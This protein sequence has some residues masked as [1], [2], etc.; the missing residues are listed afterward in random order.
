MK[1]MTVLTRRLLA[2][3]AG[4]VIALAIGGC[5]LFP[6]RDPDAGTPVPEASEP[7]GESQLPLMSEPPRESDHQNGPSPSIEVPPPIY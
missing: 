1:P 5:E 4:V 3:L 6:M 2:L 7:T